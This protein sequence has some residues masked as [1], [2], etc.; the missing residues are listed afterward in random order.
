MER[1]LHVEGHPLGITLG[2]KRKLSSLEGEVLFAESRWSTSNR[3]R[4]TLKLIGPENEFY[5]F[6]KEHHIKVGDKIR[7]HYR[8]EITLT[9]GQIIVEAYELLDNWVPETV[10]F[11]HSDKGYRFIDKEE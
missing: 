3:R 5:V 1:A 9:L 10:I 7:A 8:P 4:I 2:G 6:G 11:R